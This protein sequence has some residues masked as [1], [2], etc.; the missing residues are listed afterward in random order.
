MKAGWD[1]RDYILWSEL[2]CLPS[3]GLVAGRCGDPMVSRKDVER[4]ME[5]LAA[6]RVAAI[7]SHKEGQ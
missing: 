3:Y 7:R 2:Q 4:T 5:K 1:E 6:N